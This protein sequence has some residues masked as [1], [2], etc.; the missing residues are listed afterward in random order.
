MG[1]FFSILSPAIFA[2]SNCFDKYLLEKNHIHPIVITIFAGIFACVMGLIVLL[3]TGFYPIDVRSLCIILLSGSLTSLYILPY[4][5]AVDIDEASYVN[6]L[7]Q[8]YPLFVLFLS[9]IFLHESLSITQYTGSLLILIGGFVLAVKK[10]SSRTLSL[11]KSFF[12]MML[13]SLLFACAQVLYKFGLK[14]VPFINSLPY[15]GF[16]IAI[17]TVPILLYKGNLKFFFQ[18]IKQCKQKVFFYMI[19]NQ[20][21]YVLARYTGYFAVSLISISMVSILAGLQPLF[22]LLF[23]IILSVWFPNILKETINKKV[24]L[25]KFGSTLLMLYGLYLIFSK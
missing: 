21:I 6:P 19:I 7:F 16:G 24:L 8:F 25:Q 22:V 3:F 17:G 2:V 1:I 4:Y 23:M 14:E 5:K 11:R 13:S 12:Y 20:M 10:L 15:E 9:Y 18:E